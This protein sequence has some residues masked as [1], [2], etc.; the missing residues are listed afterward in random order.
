MAYVDIV[1]QI[2]SAGA[3]ITAYSMAEKNARSRCDGGIT[4]YTEDDF[5]RMIEEKFQG[6][7]VVEKY[8]NSKFN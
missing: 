7:H 8:I 2:E 6:W 3:L 1:T 5:V 4:L